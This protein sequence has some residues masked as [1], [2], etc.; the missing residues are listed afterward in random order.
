MTNFDFGIK[1]SCKTKRQRQRQR[2]GKR[3]GKRKVCML[4]MYLPKGQFCFKLLV[5]INICAKTKS[6]TIRAL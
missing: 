4:C 1:N 3:Q 6:I 5:V 2:T